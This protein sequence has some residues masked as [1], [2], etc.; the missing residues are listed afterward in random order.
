MN[1]L[2]E[3]DLDETD[4]PEI[5][6]LGQLSQSQWAALIPHIQYRVALENENQQSILQVGAEK[7][8]IITIK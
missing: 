3:E 5:S 6:L 4:V 8:P 2:L 7:L 1:L